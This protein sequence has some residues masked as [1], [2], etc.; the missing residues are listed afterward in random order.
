MAQYNPNKPALLQPKAPTSNVAKVGPLGGLLAAFTG[1][2]ELYNSGFNP[3]NTS[4]RIARSKE[5]LGNPETQEAPTRN[6]PW[7]GGGT[8]TSRG[9]Q[10]MKDI[11]NKAVGK[12]MDVYRSAVPAAVPQE[13]PEVAAQIESQRQVVEE[14]AKEQLRS[15]TMS[16]PKAAE[17]VVDADIQRSGEEV[18]PEEKKARV[19]EES[20][21]M[22]TMDNND[23]AKYLSYALIGTGLIASHLDESG[24]AG[25]AFAGSFENQVAREFETRE[26][27][28]RAEAKA[29]QAAVENDLAE[30]R[31][32]VTAAD[33]E[34]KIGSREATA[35]REDART[36]LMADNI[37]SQMAAR[38]SKTATDSARTQGLLDKWASDKEIA[39]GRLDAYRARTEAAGSGGKTSTGPA[40][41][42]KDNKEL[43]ESFFKAQGIKADTGVI[44]AA[45][46][47][48]GNLQKNYRDLTV[49]E[50]MEIVMDQFRDIPGSEPAWWDPWGLTGSKPKKALRGLL[51]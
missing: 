49:D 42:Y 28:K 21:V 30:R 6:I 4:D 5:M 32:G 20:A 38:S 36:A 43:S 39:Q 3:M 9:Q 25:R 41:S 44:E 10:I 51:Q 17:A 40:M 16:R 45:A 47:Q 11:S 26:A 15:N 48:L 14:G 29:Q 33:V 22:K 13:A 34:S 23:L 18:T 12:A 24:N 50:Q 46:S 1:G 27:A 37:G 8:N 2:E 7:E 35:S 31:L 19:A